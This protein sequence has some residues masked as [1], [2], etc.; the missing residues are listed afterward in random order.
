M[1]SRT[2]IG[3]GSFG[4]VYLGWTSVSINARYIS[5]WGRLG[6][7]VYMGEL[8]RVC[9]LQG[10]KEEVAV[11]SVSKSYFKQDAKVREN[12]FREIRIMQHLKSCEYVVRLHYVEVDSDCSS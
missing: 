3:K 7:C 11:K 9:W 8:T 12:L 10:G 1:A 6:V 4:E 2:R 5:Q